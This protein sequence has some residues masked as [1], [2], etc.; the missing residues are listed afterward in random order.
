M[1]SGEVGTAD[2]WPGESVPGDAGPSAVLSGPNFAGSASVLAGGSGSWANP[3]NATGGD[4]GT[5]TVWT[6]P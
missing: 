5:Y 1:L 6:V 4:D 3:S 2:A